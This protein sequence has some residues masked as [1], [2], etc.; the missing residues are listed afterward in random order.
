M[1]RDLDDIRNLDVPLILYAGPQIAHAA[2]LPGPSELAAEL[3]REAEDYLSA[4]QH[5]ELSS[6]ASGPDLGDVFTELERALTPATFGSIVERAL[7]DGSR[8]VPA[9][10]TALASLAPRLRGVITPN[11]DLLL[12]RAFEGQLIPHARPVAD[13]ASRKGWLF[14]LCG[15]LHDRSTWVLTGEQRS[16]ALHVD[17]L[18]RDLFRSLFLAH[19]IL[20]VG[21][22]LDDPLLLGLVDQI[23]ALAQGQPPNHWALVGAGEAGPIRRRKFAAAGI[24]L[25]ACEP[26]G[27]EDEHAACVRVLAQLAS[28]EAPA[29]VAAPSSPP[30]P[31]PAPA[32]SPAPSSAP[33]PSQSPSSTTAPSPSAAHSVLFVAANPSST[34]PLRIDRE[35]RVIRDAIERSRHRDSLDIEI[36]TAAT[37]HDL[38]R[39]LLERPYTILH[40]SGH[41]EEDGLLLEDE[42]GRVVEVS[43]DALARLFSRYSSTGSLR[44]VL[45]NACWSRAL[46]ES[47]DMSVPLTIAMDGPVSDAGAVEFS[48]GFYD[49]LG[50]GH[51]IAAAYTEG[52]TCVDLS[53]VPAAAFDCRLIRK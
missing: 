10:A 38:R 50:A 15:T 47:P 6:L 19:P 25:I 26:E 22:K 8:E 17:P 14:K 21:T 40:I 27:D 12:E 45:L 20:F 11:L 4:R 36:R 35:L 5:R 41:G 2:G 7:D 13:L 9:M 18:H 32:A 53:G 1:S 24:R 44:C 29:P 52:M 37:I 43:K 3:L 33:A 34:D 23:T 16:R 28:G 39:A 31:A 49:A 42:Q 48:R 51:E 46:G 30:T